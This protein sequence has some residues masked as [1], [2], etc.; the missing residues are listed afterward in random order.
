[1]RVSLKARQVAGVTA[2]VG[3]AVLALSAIHLA[4]LVRV[5]LQESH[6]RGDLLARAIFQRAREV[7][8]GDQDADTGLRDDPGIRSILESSI[9]YSKNVTYAAVL[10]SSGSAIAHSFPALEGERLPRQDDL[11]T[12]LRRN[13][14]T[15]LRAVYADRTLEVEQPLLLGDQ[16]FG[17]IRI[18]LSPLLIRNDLQDALRPAAATALVALLVATVGAMLLG[19]WMLRPI[20]VIKSGLTRLGR[21]EFGVTLDLPPGDDFTD[22][23]DSFKAISA[24]LSGRR[25]ES[26]TSGGSLNSADQLRRVASLGRLLAGVAHEVRNPLNAMTI[27]VELL[28]QKLAGAPRLGPAGPSG[29][30]GRRSELTAP[31]I[32]GIGPAGGESAVRGGVASS[33]SVSGDDVCLEEA[34][35]RT[36]V[37]GAAAAQHLSVIAEEIHRL[38]EV[39]QGFLRFIRPEELRLQPISPSDLLE[40]LV[41]MV[42]PE[43][44]KTDVSVG[45][46]CPATL[47][48]IS[49][50]PAML[51]QALL[52]LALN[53]CQ[54]MP[55]G[56]T[57]RF[58]CRS[59]ARHVTVEVEDTGV[60]IAPDHLEKIFDLYFTT[61]EHGSG[62]GLSLVYRIIELHGGEVEVQSTP[63]AGTKFCLML[64]QA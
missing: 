34:E 47:P 53:A 26:G 58:R 41:R 29:S 36:T 2:I 62:I 19:Q 63:G 20:H 56:G 44:R 6:A 32:L 28:R 50:D 7:V 13:A 4:S 27:Q 23:G 60:G 10:D 12:L 64:P 5:S 24:Q 15:Q 55:D 43:A 31:S 37:N 54:A 61:K 42:E 48:E 22:L 30:E 17:S 8:A 25:E 1:M 9:A 16:P 35:T 33:T 11:S 21:G 59:A 39:V 52:N 38:D 49:V 57:L 14:L 3:L 46:D 45:I 51:K 18:G 40:D